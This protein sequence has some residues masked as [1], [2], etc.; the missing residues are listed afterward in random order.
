MPWP[1][2]FYPWR[3]RMNGNY[4]KIKIFALF[5]VFICRH[6]GGLA[7]EI[8]VGFFSR[9]PQKNAD[10]KKKNLVIWPVRPCVGT[11]LKITLTPYD[12]RMVED[13]EPIE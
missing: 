7:P 11:W 9:G 12:D 1:L 4:K 13:Q 2:I 3:N 5:C 10:Q 6:R 8:L